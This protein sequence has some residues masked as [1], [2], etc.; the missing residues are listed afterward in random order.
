[1]GDDWNDD[2]SAFESGAG[3]VVSDEKRVSQ[4]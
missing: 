2:L 1:M 3:I 4:D